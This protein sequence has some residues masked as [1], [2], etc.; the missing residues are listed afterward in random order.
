[1][2]TETLEMVQ[3]IFREQPLSLAVVFEWLSQLK[4]G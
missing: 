4:G 2:V 1:L 3:E